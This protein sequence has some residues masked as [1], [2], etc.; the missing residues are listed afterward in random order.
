MNVRTRNAVGH[1]LIALTLMAGACRG[2]HRHCGWHGGRLRRVS[3]GPGHVAGPDVGARPSAGRR[4]AVRSS[5]RAGSW[6]L[7]WS[8]RRW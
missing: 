7:R 5:G 8:C 1:T 4:A 6:R 3:A 2:S